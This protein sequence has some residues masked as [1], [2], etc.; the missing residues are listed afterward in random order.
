[1]GAATV[2]EDGW[3][4]RPVDPLSDCCL[5]LDSWP[6]PR[7]PRSIVGDPDCSAERCTIPMALPAIAPMH[8]G[9]MARANNW[10]S[11]PFMSERKFSGSWGGPYTFEA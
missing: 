4:N 3:S 2:V 9:N 11:A 1:M 5:E 10:R 6:G 7:G 8:R